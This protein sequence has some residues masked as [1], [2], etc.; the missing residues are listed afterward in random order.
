[1]VAAE[2]LMTA[3]ELIRLPTG[4]GERYALVRGVLITVRAPDVS[5]VSKA[6]VAELF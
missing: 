1:M 2:K 4:R 6:R 5:F 3:E